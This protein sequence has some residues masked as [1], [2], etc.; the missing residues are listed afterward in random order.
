MFNE[1]QKKGVTTNSQYTRIIA[2]AGSGKT[3]VLTSRI[4]Y[5]LENNLANPNGILGITFTNKA[6]H[7]IKDRVTK[8]VNN[9]QG[10]SLCTIHSWC[11]TFLRRHI[12]LLGYKTSFN[13]LDESD[14]LQ[15]M[16]DIFVSKGRVKTDP[17]LKQCLNWISY[18][19]MQGYQYK[20]LKDMEIVNSE[21]GIYLGFFE[22]YDY[23]L[24]EMNALDFDDLMLKTIEILE[25]EKNGV[26]DAYHRFIT[27]ILV[28]EFQDINNV[29]FHLI[30]LLL[31]PTCSL[32]VVGDPD[33]TIYTW[34]GANHRI[35]MDF[36]E[37]LRNIYKDA[38]VETI[39]LNQNYRSTKKILDCANKLIENNK[40]RVKKELITNQ[41]DGQDVALYKGFK[42][43]D[44]ANYI[45]TT[46][47]ELHH[48]GTLYQDIAVLYRMNYLTRE[49]EAQLNMAKIPY[50]IYGGLKFFQRKEI[51]DVLS[52]FTLLYNVAY[53]IG[54]TRIV[55]VPKRNIG[56]ASLDLLIQKAN[57]NG[58]S[59]YSYVLEEEKLPLQNSKNVT[60][61]NLVSIL[62]K[63]S[64]KIK[65]CDKSMITTI[66]SD[67]LNEIE[68][69]KEL[70]QDPS[71]KDER[72]ENIDEL[73]ATMQD[74]F[75][76]EENPSFEEFIENCVLQSAQDEVIN[77][78][79]VTLMTVHAS[80]GL[81]FD[82]VFI[83]SF[84][85]G[86]F[87]SRKAIEESRNGIEEERRLAYVALTRA[88]K[89]L[90]IS[91]N[92]DYSLVQHVT[93]KPSRFIKECGLIFKEQ[94]IPQKSNA[95]ASWDYYKDTKKKVENKTLPS[96]Q[97]NNISSWSKG[98]LISHDVFGIG[99]VTNYNPSTK[100][101][102]VVFNDAK[103]GTKNLLS[104]HYM[105]KKVV[106]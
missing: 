32:Y 96:M 3:R 102:T 33:Q 93:N 90:Y 4:A 83:Y 41:N 68:Y 51:K 50:K 25:D 31:S 22:A 20:D 27:H 6:A 65:T 55:N 1:N 19:K 79:F 77:G 105:I 103:F 59:L 5:L 106:N 73:L 21:I 14:T 98:D 42:E 95:R 29:Q 84:C 54:F 81:E 46:I 7:E 53:D 45:A 85:D 16:K 86:I 35:I 9:C 71:K 63:Y 44:E 52:Y 75:D 56:Q 101:I 66:L 72:Q 97:K 38:K 26:K 69:E 57:E 74:Y 47:K 11:A 2:G 87:P 18:K 24:K 89:K 76:N 62:E 48:Q 12:K 43:K 37:N 13:I 82:N 67:L 92:E 34:R 94:T 91:T 70:D 17:M 78:D 104:T 100:I 99:I 61:K 80:K 30:S 28:D 15:V 58:Q 39:I 23:R 40:Q 10:M 49:L 64:N 36:E 88:R 60:L 8:I